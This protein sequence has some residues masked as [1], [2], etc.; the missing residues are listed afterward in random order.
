MTPEAIEPRVSDALKMLQKEIDDT[1]LC[2]RKGFALD[3]AL[4]I[5]TS[6]ALRIGLAVCKLVASGFYGE[7]FGL[8]RS[9]LEAFFIVKYISGKDA[10]NRADS[11]LEFRKTY[12]YNQEMIRRKHFPHTEQPARLTQKMLDEIKQRFPKTRHWVPAY[13]M[14]SD[15]YEHPLDTDPKSGKGYQALDVYDGIYEMTSHYV[16]VTAFSCMANF[17]AS[18]FRTS[19]SDKEE[20]RAI[21]AL[22]FSLLYVYATCIILGRH[23]ECTLSEGVNDEVQ[24]LLAELR[25]VP[26]VNER[27]LWTS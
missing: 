10:E 1:L 14:A 4:L 20:D 9:V 8:T 17:D 22:H 5:V 2:P 15:Y 25:A 24:T 18:P 26:S 7:A 6:R 13:S 11:Y 23:W 3:Q 12:Q 19:K 21:L 27:G 16:H